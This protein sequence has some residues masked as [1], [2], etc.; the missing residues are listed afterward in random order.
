MLENEAFEME[1][2]VTQRFLLKGFLYMS[3]FI[4]IEDPWSLTSMPLY[5]DGYLSS[6]VQLIQMAANPQ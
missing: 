3:S 5:E 6:E 4:V 1:M 2:F